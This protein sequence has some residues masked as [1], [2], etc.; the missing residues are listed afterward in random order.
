MVVTNMSK[1]S[2]ILIA[3][4][5]LFIKY[6]IDHI[7]MVDIAK[8]AGVSKQTIYTYF[9]NKN[10]LFD[11]SFDYYCKN[12]QYRPPNLSDELSLYDFLSI[13][14]ESILEFIKDD[15]TINIYRA[16]VSARLTDNDLWGYAFNNGLKLAIDGLVRYLRIKKERGEMVVGDVEGAAASYIS[17]LVSVELLHGLLGYPKNYCDNYENRIINF[18]NSFS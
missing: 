9:G 5:N 12:H 1:E 6:G 13:Y 4:S 8:T 7:N 15:K 17:S 14:S 10:I 16:C 18:V 11:R 2:S 3:A